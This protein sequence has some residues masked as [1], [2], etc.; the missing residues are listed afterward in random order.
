MIHTII[1]DD[2]TGANDTGIQ[3][4]DNGVD[5]VVLVRP[6]KKVDNRFI[7]SSVLI[8]DTESRHLDA[9]EAYNAIVETVQLFT[10][11]REGSILKKIDSTLRG[12]IGAE[13]DALMDYV[14]YQYSFVISAAPEN[15]RV[16]RDGVCYIHD[17]E[18]SESEF[19]KDPF[20]PVDISFIPEIIARQSRRKVGLVT[21]KDIKQSENH[22]RNTIK[23]QQS[24]G[25]QIIVFDTLQQSDIEKIVKTAYELKEKILFV[26]SSGLGRIV[27]GNKTQKVDTFF[28]ISLKPLFIIG[29]LT[30]LSSAQA[31]HLIRTDNSFEI[32]EIETERILH[33][34]TPELSMKKQ[35]METAY[36][37]EK[38]IVLK[39]RQE[40][41]YKESFS[42]LNN[43]GKTVAKKLGEIARWAVI[44]LGVR[45]LFVTG[46]ETAFNIVNSL[47]IDSLRLKTEILP[48]IP[49]CEACIDGRKEPLHIITK[50]GGFGDELTLVKIMDFIKN[51]GKMQKDKINS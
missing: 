51:N 9:Q 50:A 6:Q 19:G 34:N 20:A 41:N 25:K 8:I 43:T 32:I 4:M 42:V 11:V 39:T 37:S 21:Y 18:L 49:L 15:G 40:N 36:K 47:N 10:G 22:L 44:D 30:K 23:E 33:N 45:T 12:N 29:S 16:V 7:S 5:P 13:I 46:G 2:F 24:E 17:V 28:N 27:N 14:N 35:K 1:A 38:C 26:G 31:D 48:G 3:F